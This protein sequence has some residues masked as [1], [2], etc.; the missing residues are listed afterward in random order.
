MLYDYHS[1]QNAEKP[2]SIYATYLLSGIKKKTQEDGDI[3][4]SSSMPENDEDVPITTLTLVGQDKLKAYGLHA[5]IEDIMAEYQEVS[6]I[7]IYSLA[8][9]PQRDLAVISDLSRSL[10]EYTAKDRDTKKY[11]A[12]ENPYVRRRER[13]A[14]PAMAAAAAP[15][16]PRPVKTEPAPAVKSETN[17]ELPTAAAAAPQKTNPFTAAT[18]N[19]SKV[20]KELGAGGDSSK[21]ST[22]APKGPA[23]KRGGIMQSFAKAASKPPKP[24]AEVKKE[25]DT[26]MALSDDGEADDD[27]IISTKEKTKTDDR[28]DNSTGRKS[29]KQREEELRR[30]MEEEEAEEEEEEMEEVDPADQEMDEAPEPEPEP[31][32]ETK[33]ESVDEPQEVVKTENGRRRG[34]RRIMKKKRILDEQGYMVTIQE[35]GWE[36]FSEDEAPPPAKKA[37]STPTTSSSTSAASK[38]K[39]APAKGGQGNI[40]SFFSKK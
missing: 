27:D 11:G 13:Q 3:E 25:E 40:M 38:T 9:H 36:S 22:P 35:P 18:A 7:H 23:S 30:M 6:S 32:P 10:A 2:E 29:R 15:A 14:R 37:A 39:K 33:D 19:S 16:K 4:M 34:K 5:G 21:E 26:A 8:P 28:N 1:Y 12:V 17:P 24:K 31:E 20:K